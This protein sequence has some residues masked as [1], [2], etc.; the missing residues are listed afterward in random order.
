MQQAHDADADFWRVSLADQIAEVKRE[1]EMRKAVYPRLIGQEK[2]TPSEGETFML[3]MIGVLRT[4][5]WVRDEGLEPSWLIRYG[6]GL[7]R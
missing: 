1:I 5:E 6:D 7:Q 3:R 2:M 4:L